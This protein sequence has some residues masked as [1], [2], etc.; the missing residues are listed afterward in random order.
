M[1]IKLELQDLRQ[2]YDILAKENE[3]IEAKYNLIAVKKFPYLT[4]YLRQNIKLWRLI[5]G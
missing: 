1:E 5:L 3:E 4:N 2:R